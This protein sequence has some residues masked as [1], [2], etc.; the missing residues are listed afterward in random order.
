[1]SRRRTCN[2]KKTL[3]HVKAMSQYT[4]TRLKEAK[5]LSK[6]Q[7]LHPLVADLDMN[8]N[9]QHLLDVG[10]YLRDHMTANPDWASR[11]IPHPLRSG[12]ILNS[13]RAMRLMKRYKKQGGKIDQAA[14]DAIKKRYYPF[15]R[16]DRRSSFFVPS[17]QTAADIGRVAGQ[18]PAVAAAAAVA[19]ERAAEAANGTA[20]RAAKEAAAAVES[21]KEARAMGD[22]QGVA[23][24]AAAATEAVNSAKVAA[25]EERAAEAVAEAQAEAADAAAVAAAPPGPA[26]QK[27]KR[28]AKEKARRRQKRRERRQKR[29][30]AAQRFGAG[31]L[32]LG[33]ESFQ[34]VA[35]A[36]RRAG[37]SVPQ[38]QVQNGLASAASTSMGLLAL[39]ASV[40]VFKLF[41]F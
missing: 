16:V 1:M 18:A 39:W 21:V 12:R 11:G 2:E 33:A 7:S 36:G 4:P 34:Q 22:A 15:Q 29:V 30:Q 14:F 5:R 28:T 25:A 10:D 41:K 40:N 8:G 19:S 6:I 38:D 20:V 31:A 24:A 13:G 35:A 37:E 32:S 17:K 9:P 23:A 3:R 27:A 26:K